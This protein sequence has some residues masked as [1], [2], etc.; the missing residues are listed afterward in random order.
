MYKASTLRRERDEMA[1]QASK[2]ARDKEL[3]ASLKSQ[4]WEAVKTAQALR[5]EIATLQVRYQSLRNKRALKL[6]ITFLLCMLG[7]R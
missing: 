7:G 4:H 6:H 1:A 2:D 3:M 5:A